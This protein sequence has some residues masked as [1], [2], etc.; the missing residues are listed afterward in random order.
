M[1]RCMLP[2]FTVLMAIAAV[3]T[4]IPRQVKAQPA[5]ASNE[6]RA[7]A[8]FY[9]GVEKLKNGDNE[10]A[11]VD[12]EASFAL[13]PKSVTVLNLAETYEK[14]GKLAS[15]WARYGELIHLAKKEG[16]D[17]RVAYGQKH[18]LELEARIPR[19]VIS[20][21]GVDNDGLEVERDGQTVEHTQLNVP[22]YV[23]PGEHTVTATKA[24]VAESFFKKVT[25]RE[26]ET[27]R[28]EIAFKPPPAELPSPWIG[29]AAAG[30]G[31]AVLGTGIALGISAKNLENSAYDSGLCKPESKQCTLEGQDKIDR[32]RGRALPANILMGAGLL[33]VAAGA[34]WYVWVKKKSNREST[35]RI[36]PVTGPNEVGVAVIGRF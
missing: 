3:Q 17:E 20:V 27:A 29:I 28:V 6:D 22:I 30:T 36:L 14:V 4:V 21:V 35:A 23:D 11:I 24:G 34:G 15:A 32:A 9:A 1:Q 10:G 12:F 19:L 25:I 7:R 5:S 26:K 33:A 2:I 13:V 31:L 8:Y 18:I 16:D